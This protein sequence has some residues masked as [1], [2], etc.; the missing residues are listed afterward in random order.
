MAGFDIVANVIVAGLDQLKRLGDLAKK[1]GDEASKAGEEVEGLGEKAKGAGEEFEGAGEKAKGAG[2]EFDGAGGKSKGAGEE[3]DGAGKKAKGAGDKLEKAA[4]QFRAMGS[5]GTFAGDSLE[6]F[7]IVTSGPMGAAI[8]GAVVA[9]AGLK[10]AIAAVKATVNGLTTSISTYIQT[11]LPLQRSQSKLNAQFKTLAATFGAALIGGESFGKVMEV[12][13]EIIDKVTDFVVENNGVILKFTKTFSSVAKVLVQIFLGIIT[14]ITAPMTGMADLITFTINKLVANFALVQMD[15]L[16]MTMALPDAVK[17]AF[18]L[19][20]DALAK[21]YASAEKRAAAGAKGAGD[22]FK[23]GFSAKMLEAAGEVNKAV[24]QID[25]AIQQ[26]TPS[27]GRVTVKPE[28]VGTP[29]APTDQLSPDRITLQSFLPITVARRSLEIAQLRKQNE[30]DFGEINALMEAY[31][32]KANAIAAQ[33]LRG[34]ARARELDK[35]S[36]ATEDLNKRLDAADEAAKDLAVGS[37]SQL[38]SS[39]MQTMGA[40]TVGASSLRD[41]GDAMAD[42]AARIASDFGSLFIKLGAG[43]V[44]TPGSQALGAGMIAAGLGLQFLSGILGAKGS[45][46]AGGGGG[47]GRAAAASTDNSIA[48]EVSRSLRP[49]GDDGPAITNIEVVIGGR[50]IQ[51]EMVGIID[52]IVRQRRSR[53]LG[54]RAGI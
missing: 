27:A 38:G 19:T 9:F 52:D 17:K 30:K 16:E 51:P 36:K 6:R 5:A 43:F 13:G 31:M 44:I 35:I 32:Q 26:L 37:L 15:I 25:A 10:V 41:F 53:Y 1:A 33:T 2:E 3:F 23:K 21:E 54:R 28:P 45:A 47:G 24:T 20:D 49:S 12:V 39:I 4:Q 34:E 42:L 14:G 18:G 29:A 11:S 50:S 8:A 48:R 7:S 40:F 46:N 22:A